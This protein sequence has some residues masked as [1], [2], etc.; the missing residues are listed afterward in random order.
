MLQLGCWLFDDHLYKRTL[1]P[2]G[3]LHPN[4]ILSATLP[5]LGP[6]PKHPWRLFCLFCAALSGSR[7]VKWSLLDLSLWERLMQ[8]NTKSWAEIWGVL[9]P[10]LPVSHSA[11]LGL[12]NCSR[13]KSQREGCESVPLAQFDVREKDLQCCRPRQCQKLCG[14]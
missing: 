1:Y 3:H 2:K 12:A 4:Q 13:G 6:M 9:L 11:N 5:G 8:R 14:S 10:E 7:I